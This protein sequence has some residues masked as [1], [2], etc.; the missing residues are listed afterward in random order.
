MPSDDSIL[1]SIHITYCFCGG[2]E[3]VRWNHSRSGRFPR[4]CGSR[5]LGL[6]VLLR[7]G[8]EGL[9]CLGRRTLLRERSLRWNFTWILWLPVG[10]IHCLTFCLFFCGRWLCLSCWDC[11]RQKMRVHSASSNWKRLGGSRLRWL[12]CLTFLM[13]LFF[14]RA[15]RSRPTSAFG[16]RICLLIRTCST[17]LAMLLLLLLLFLLLL[18]W[19]FRPLFSFL[20]L[21]FPSVHVV[22]YYIS[23]DEK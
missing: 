9:R 11:T 12:Y 3:C 8:A 1:A 16:S 21:F 14:W 2:F 6:A 13:F 17:V 15:E 5:N 19:V 4:R 22:N 18:M 7:P 23:V 10:P 20:G